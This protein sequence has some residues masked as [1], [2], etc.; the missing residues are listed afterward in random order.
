MAVIQA[1]PRSR[2]HRFP[3]KRTSYIGARPQAR[4]RPQGWPVHRLQHRRRS[5]TLRGLAMPLRL[6]R[7]PKSPNWIIRGTVRGIR[8]EESSGVVLAN[9]RAAEEIRAKREAEILSESVF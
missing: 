2:R 8:V 4:H 5:E 7:R 6:V 1:C 3:S 9:R